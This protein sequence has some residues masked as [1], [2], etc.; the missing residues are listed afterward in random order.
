MSK[1]AVSVVII[2][3]N[4]E[5]NIQRCLESLRWADEIIIVDAFSNDNTLTISASYTDKI[6]QRE[7]PGYSEQK[8]FGLSRAAYE[9]VIFIDADEKISFPLANAINKV[10]QGGSEFSGYYFLRQSF[11][12]GRRIKYG[13][14][15]P[16]WK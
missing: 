5:R 15:N 10:L 8:N 7:W 6:F 9:W 4:E 16:D 14:W 2:T 1:E 12:L 11:Y 3:Y 13:E